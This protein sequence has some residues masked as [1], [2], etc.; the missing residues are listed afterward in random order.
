MRSAAAAIETDQI[1]RRG[2][3]SGVQLRV[4]SIREPGIGVVERESFKMTI[5]HGHQ[6]ARANGPFTTSVGERRSQSPGLH[7]TF[8]FSPTCYPAAF[9]R[10]DAS[11]TSGVNC[12]LSKSYTQTSPVRIE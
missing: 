3:W 8:A 1:R 4:E 9:T 6:D 12:S 5:A 10:G 7:E 2:E 11:S